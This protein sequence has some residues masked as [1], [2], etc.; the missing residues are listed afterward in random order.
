MPHPHL[1]VI[2]PAYNEAGRIVAT[3]DAV[4]QYLQQQAYTAEVITVDDGSDDSTAE[5]VE[6]W[7]AEQED[8]RLE[9]IEHGGKG[10]AVRQG[11][12][13]ASGEYR[14]MCDADLAMPIDHLADFLQ[15]M[16]S[17]YDIVIGSRQIAGANRYGES[18]F[19]H[20]LGRT[21]NKMVQVIA[22]RGID[23]TQCGFK[24]FSAA[25]AETLFPLQHVKGWGFDVE[26]LFLARRLGMRVLEI[27][28]EW[29][30]DAD[31]RLN[32]ASAG[33][34][35]LRDV[36]A[37]R[38]NSLRGKYSQEYAYSS[39]ADAGR[40]ASAAASTTTNISGGDG[41][42][43]HNGGLA[44]LATA[45]S[46]NRIAP[47]D[48]APCGY[49]AIVVPTFNEAENLPL[50]AER[51]FALR[52][53]D[54][55]LVV[56]DDNSPDGTAEVARRL[57]EQYDNRIDLIERQ[58]KD[59]LGTAYKVGFRHA[60]EQGAG[61]VLQM[62]ADLSHAP[63]YIPDFLKTLRQSD[64]VVGSRYTQGGGV[65]KD[66]RFRRHLL[67]S[68][69][70]YGIRAVVGLKVKDA[71]TGFKAFRADALNALDFDEFRCKGFGFQAEVAYACQHGNY[72]VV[73]HPITFYDRAHGESK[74]SM[75]IIIEALWRLFLLRWRRKT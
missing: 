62:D 67:S 6:H 39:A 53:P 65:D 49:P 61:Y 27:P 29:R 64:V 42:D 63:E 11:M 20:M 12:L 56:V 68:L 73:E 37:V 54:L 14:F 36:L 8:F 46:T 35:M 24:C 23:D 40:A 58:S 19:R 51:L 10:A 34:N 74:L 9:R 7:S 21:Y 48:D 41:A 3:L 55:R 4:S 52:L 32:P 31:S 2:I 57:N 38:W 17:G 44:E 22:V 5:V 50:L 47:D 71:T 28:I 43:S 16:E 45:A 30:H 59:G 26:L 72:R 69:A 66:W 25:A 15:H 60:I 75:G 13:A 1:S 18:L 70:N 33:L